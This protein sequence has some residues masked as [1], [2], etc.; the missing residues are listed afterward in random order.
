MAADYSNPQYM[1][2]TQ[3]LQAM[4]EGTP[5]SHDALGS[6]PSFDKTTGAM[7]QKFHETWY[8]P[9]NAI[10]IIAGDV[11]PDRVIAEVKSLFGDI[12]RKEPS[13]AAGG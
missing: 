3:L 13:R 2:Y 5:Y 1:F 10:L 9:N 6:R 12:S 7:L 8:A 11:Q 4:F